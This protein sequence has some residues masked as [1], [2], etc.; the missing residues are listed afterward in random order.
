MT[1]MP[2]FLSNY[3]IQ[4]R[5][6]SSTFRFIYS[7]IVFRHECIGIRQL[8]PLLDLDILTSF[9]GLSFQMLRP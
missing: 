4:S 6:L 5:A 7:L 1:F 8:V 9:A 3:R 2:T